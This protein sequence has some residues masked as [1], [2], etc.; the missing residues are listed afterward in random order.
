MAVASGWLG[1]S[2]Q[3]STDEA[4]RAVLLVK[5]SAQ[6]SFEKVLYTGDVR[7]VT[8]R[9]IADVPV[10]VT[11]IEI[12]SPDGSLKASFPSNGF[13]NITEIPPKEAVELDRSVVPSCGSCVSLETLRLRVWYVAS[14]LF[15]E[16]NPAAS[17]DEMRYVETVF[18]YPVGAIS[19]TCPLPSSWITVDVVDP[20]TLFDLGRIPNPPNN[21]IYVRFPYASSRTNVAVDLQVVNATGEWGTASNTVLS[22]SNEMQAFTG[23]IAGFQVPL[24]VTVIA[25]GFDVRPAVWVFGGISG[26][27]H[28]IW[29]DALVGCRVDG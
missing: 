16:D 9:N 27:A 1:V 24:R 23:S 3:S 25:A 5:T 7:N 8:L 14:G 12:V 10:V 6:L 29:L 21:K 22:M 4:N 17:A 18:T 13:A 28:G 19:P 26:K 15:Q 2:L 11:R 20:V